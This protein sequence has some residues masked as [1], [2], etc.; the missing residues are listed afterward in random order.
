MSLFFFL[1][2][3]VPFSIPTFSLTILEMSLE[4]LLA[5]FVPKSPPPI[6]DAEP[7]VAQPTYGDWSARCLRRIRSFAGI[8]NW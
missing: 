5:V 6:F 2:I 8:G 1:A 4:C 7:V 3:F